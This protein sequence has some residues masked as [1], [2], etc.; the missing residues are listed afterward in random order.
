MTD[1]ET[2]EYLRAY[3][4]KCNFGGPV[5]KYGSIGRG[6][7]RI[8]FFDDENGWFGERVDDGPINIVKRKDGVDTAVK[9]FTDE[10]QVPVDD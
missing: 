3:L 8:G 1:E 9:A 4:S 7:K 10:Y 5:G 6:T 2:M